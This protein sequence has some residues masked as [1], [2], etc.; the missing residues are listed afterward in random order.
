MRTIPIWALA[1]ALSGCVCHSH[2]LGAV[3]D[4]TNAKPLVGARL[5]I[6]GTDAAVETDPAGEY[7]I[8]AVCR[9]EPYVVVITASGYEDLREEMV[10]EGHEKLRD[11]QLTPLD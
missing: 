4:K 6:E 8:E 7:E 2:L 1:L 5:S 9:N 11:F 10:L 3:E